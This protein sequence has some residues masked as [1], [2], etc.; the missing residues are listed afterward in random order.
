MSNAPHER[1]RI[2]LPVR[3]ETRPLSHW[4]AACYG[5][6]LWPVRRFK[7]APVEFVRGFQMS[8]EIGNTMPARVK[9]K[10][11]RDFQEIERLVQFARAAIEPVGILS[12]AIEIDTR[13][14]Q[15]I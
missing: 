11:M 3:R 9:M 7:N 13:F 15:Q 12:A 14:C 6:Q 8:E 2:A 5:N 10:F 4:L 1:G